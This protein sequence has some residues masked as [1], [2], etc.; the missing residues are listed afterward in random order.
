MRGHAWNFSQEQ[1]LS[2]LA[3]VDAIAQQIGVDIEPTIL[4]NAQGEIRDQYPSL[5]DA[6]ARL[7]HDYRFDILLTRTAPPDGPVEH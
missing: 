2:V 7:V 1:P 4:D 5:T 3:L 6:L